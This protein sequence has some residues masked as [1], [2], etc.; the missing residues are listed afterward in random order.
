MQ[1]SKIHNLAEEMP[2]KPTPAI[3]MSSTKIPEQ[4]ILKLFAEERRHDQ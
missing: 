3:E 4:F 1:N 2:R